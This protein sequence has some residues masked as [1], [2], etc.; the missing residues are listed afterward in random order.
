MPTVLGES[1]LGLADGVGVAVGVAAAVDDDVEG[2][3]DE[4]AAELLL[5]TGGS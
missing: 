3:V 1:L 4:G 2:A 5:D